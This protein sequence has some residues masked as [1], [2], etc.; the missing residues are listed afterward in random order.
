MDKRAKPK[1]S[2]GAAVAAALWLAGALLCAAGTAAAQPDQTPPGA[3]HAVPP[4][5]PAAKPGFFG[6][7]G[8]WWDTSIGF[9]HD[10]IKE[11]PATFGDLGKKSGETAKEAAEGAA[12]VTEDAVKKTFDVGKDAA[13]TIGR[14]PDT[15]VIEMHATCGKAPNGAPDCATAAAD[16]CRGRGFKGGKAVDVG[17]AVKCDAAKAAAAGQAPAKGDCPIESWV[18]RAVCQ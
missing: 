9:F 2:C 18:T 5:P 8:H 11:T 1:R 3:A 4:Q 6:T 12:A 16:A 17:T 13:T 7:L 14:L 15:R 10:R